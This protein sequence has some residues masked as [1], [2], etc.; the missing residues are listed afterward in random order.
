MAP[1]ARALQP[2]ASYADGRVQVYEDDDELL[3]TEM[4]GKRKISGPDGPKTGFFACVFNLANVAMGAGVLA[5]PYTM[6]N[7]GYISGPIL[8]CIAASIMFYTLQ[9]VARCADRAYEL[10]REGRAVMNEGSYQEIVVAILGKFWGKVLTWVLLI[11]LTLSNVC[12]MTILYDQA[13]PIILS[14]LG[15][16]SAFN[17]RYILVPLCG[18]L[19]CYPLALIPNMSVFS[20]PS[21]LS[22]VGVMFGVLLVTYYCFRDFPSNKSEPSYKPPLGKA[23]PE[24]ME[25][26]DAFPIFAF[27]FQCHI[28]FPLIY[29]SM[30]DRTFKKIT[31]VNAT[32]IVFCLSIYLLM[33][34]SGYLLL[35]A[36]T[37]G[38]ILAGLCGEGDYYDPK[39][40]D[41]CCVPLLNSTTVLKV[42]PETKVDILNVIARVCVFIKVVCS[43]AMLVFVSRT[44]VKDLLLPQGK[45]FTRVQ[46]HIETIVYVA[47]TIGMGIVM[48]SMTLPM[49]FAGIL[50]IVIDIIYPGV[51]Q[52]KISTTQS[53]KAIGYVLVAF[54]VLLVIMSVVSAALK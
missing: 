46:F 32:T 4:G 20:I 43:Y 34:I 12:F 25:Y 19:L 13:E 47:F 21:T 45:P 15:P 49:Q 16:D 35:G 27:S 42:C 38:D 11:Y 26:L 52:V 8:A 17:E 41:G 37:P 50:V 24:V 51:M 44:C 14:Q 5:Y 31:A 2:S 1:V 6:R 28:T 54:G 53:G 39:L 9:T 3:G 22:Q 10:E 30:K 40:Q 23:T 48:K 36:A 18:G 33:G 29:A 7:T